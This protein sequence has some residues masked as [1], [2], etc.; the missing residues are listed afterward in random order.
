MIKNDATST[1]KKVTPG[2]AARLLGISRTH[3]DALLRTGQIPFTVAANG[4][5]LI[6]VA[7]LAAWTERRHAS[8][9]AWYARRGRT[10]PTIGL[11]HSS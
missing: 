5:R 2:K 3:M 6:A 1:P 4:Y 7:D 8:R 11:H 9:E 10:V